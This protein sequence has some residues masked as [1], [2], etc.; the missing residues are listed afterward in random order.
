MVTVQIKI[1][2]ELDIDIEVDTLMEQ[3]LREALAEEVNNYHIEDILNSIEV[4]G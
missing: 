2:L 1:E 4:I 3:T